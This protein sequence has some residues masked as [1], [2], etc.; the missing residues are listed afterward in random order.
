[1]QKYIFGSATGIY[2]I[3]L[4]EN[5]QEVPGAL[6]VRP[7]SGSAGHDAPSSHQ[8]A[9]P[10]DVFEERGRLRD[11]LREP[12]VAGP[13]RSRLHGRSQSITRLR[14]SEEMKE[15]AQYERLPRKEALESDG[16]REKLDKALVGIK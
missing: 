5:T 7:R 4:Q 10:G 9:G 15:P 6:R 16:R 12:A 3:D 11:V 8:E 13:V 1:M 14:S 2:I